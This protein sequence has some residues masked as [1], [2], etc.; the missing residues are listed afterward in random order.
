[1][2]FKSAFPNS[3]DVS[4]VFS[5]VSV[6]YTSIQT[7]SIDIAENQHDMAIIEFVGLLPKAITDYVGTPVYI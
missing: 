4:V 6:D 2:I 3:P 1:M 5:G 7:V